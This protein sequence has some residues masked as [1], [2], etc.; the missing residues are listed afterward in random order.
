MASGEHLSSSLGSFQCAEAQHLRE[1]LRVLTLEEL[2]L[3]IWADPLR[4]RVIGSAALRT[5]Y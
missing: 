2:S 3:Q 5:C 1:L 4:H